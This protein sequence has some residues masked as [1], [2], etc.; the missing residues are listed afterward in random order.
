MQQN[1]IYLDLACRL[2][3]LLATT[4]TVF[5]IAHCWRTQPDGLMARFICHRHQVWFAV[6]LFFLPL[7]LGVTVVR[8]VYMHLPAP[9]GEIDYRTMLSLVLN[10]VYGVGYGLAGGLLAS[11][12]REGTFRQWLAWGIA[13]APTL[14]FAVC[15]GAAVSLRGRGGVFALIFTGYAPTVLASVLFLAAVAAMTLRAKQGA[16]VLDEATASPAGSPA[17]ALL[18]GFL[19]SVM[20]LLL[21]LIGKTAA[22]EAIVPLLLMG[23]LV[24]L[25]C[26]F[27]TS[28]LLFRRRT[29]LAIFGGVM[30]LVLNLVISIGFAIGF[31]CSQMRF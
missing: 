21:V 10:L 29:G 31:G 15:F 12:K 30:L 6:A 23:C 27:A 5:W 24:S 25:I 2:V 22:R 26:C 3:G 16:A 19:P 13:V 8:Y 18:L 9:A 1:F 7:I 28:F 20:I 4:G 14:F 11:M 17:I